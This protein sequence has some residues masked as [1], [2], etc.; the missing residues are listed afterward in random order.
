MLMMRHQ[1]GIIKLN[2]YSKNVF[3]YLDT[4]FYI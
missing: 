4:F 2:R 3:K 1:M